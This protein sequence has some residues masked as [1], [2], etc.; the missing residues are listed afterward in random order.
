RV[1]PGGPSTRIIRAPRGSCSWRVPLI[2]SETTL[3][4]VVCIERGGD[5]SVDSAEV[6]ARA[7]EG[8]TIRQDNAHLIAV[9]VCK[10]CRLHAVAR[11]RLRREGSEPVAL[12]HGNVSRLRRACFLVAN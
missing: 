10:R 2:D 4:R 11:F 8:D 12:P 7:G 9:V 1:I 3:S 6:I 5:S